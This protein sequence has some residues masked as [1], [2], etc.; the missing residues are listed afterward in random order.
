VPPELVGLP[1][2][3]STT[4]ANVQNFFDG[5]WRMYLR[6]RAQMVT[7]AIS[8]WALPRGTVLEVNRDAYIRPG[9]LERA[10]IDQILNAIQDPAGNPAKT[11]DEIRQAERFIDPDPDL[12]QGVLRG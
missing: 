8:E 3:G 5:H 7:A 2:S 11:V 6:P 1:G 10:Q 9:P 12:A 4:Y